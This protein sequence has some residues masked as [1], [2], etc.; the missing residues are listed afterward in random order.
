VRIEVDCER[1]RRNTESIVGLCAKHGIEVV[2]V[3]KS[4]CG[5]P[6][7]A[8]A[9]LAGGL[10]LQGADQAILCLADLWSEFDA[11]GDDAVESFSAC[12]SSHLEVGTHGCGSSREE[13]IQALHLAETLHLQ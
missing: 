4:V 3:T 5:N 6:D 2:G 1:I 7:V 9:M 12:L 13:D 11:A 8:R 10:S